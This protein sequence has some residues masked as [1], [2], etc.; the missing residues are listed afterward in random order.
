[1]NTRKLWAAT[2]LCAGLGAAG[3]AQAQA[4]PAGQ[5]P[6]S[7]AFAAG[8][9]IKLMVGYAPGGPVDTAARVFAPYF[10]KETGATV[11]VENRPGAAGALGGEPVSRAQPV[12]SAAG[13]LLL[14][15]SA[16]PT[17]TITP[18]LLKAMP[19]DPVN[20]I[21][22]LAP[23]VSYAN[24]LV[25]NKDQP[26]KTLPELL[27]Y[28]KA[29]PGKVTYG[30]AGIGAS[31]H[32]SGELLAQ[33]TGTQ[34]NH[35]PYRGSAPALNDVI[36]GQ[37]S[38]MFDIPITSRSH[39]AAGKV[40]ALAVTSRERNAS[41]PNV[42]TLSELGVKDYEVAGWFGVF[43]P[44]KMAPELVQQLNAA[45]RR[46]LA[47]KELEAKLVEAGFDVW[48]G[49]AQALGE[50]LVKELAL[51]APIAKGIPQQ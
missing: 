37:I 14:F 41:L 1:M 47:N 28:A 18:H 48:S 44:P 22:P 31:N 13:G 46:A 12:L 30:S 9:T 33:R 23:V 32:L 20:G 35:V 2:L 39:I 45:T 25:V 38:M 29:N 4:Q 36:G 7:P 26:F 42:P 40:N 6:G 50:R 49:S 24:V 34:M 16:S 3:W 43:G 8:Q 15:F 19:F 5:A 17:V 11:V 27:A 51:W 10:A 21:T